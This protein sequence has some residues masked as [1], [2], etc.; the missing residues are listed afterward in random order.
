MTPS[1]AAGGGAD[2]FV[3]LLSVLC[4]GATLLFLAIRFALILARA[5]EIE[6]VAAK[7]KVERDALE[8]RANELETMQ[9]EVE[10]QRAVLAELEAE[11]LVLGRRGRKRTAGSRR[12][13]HEIGRP[14]VGRLLFRFTLSMLPGAMQRPDAKAVVHPAIWPFRNEAQVWSTDYPAAQMLTRSIFNETVGVTFVSSDA[15]KAAPDSAA[16]PPPTAPAPGA[17]AS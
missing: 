9:A 10:A 15:E 12:F 1:A 13:I 8:V 3:V 4:I 17:A 7:L 2:D 14:E 16:A 11:R 5:R 6:R